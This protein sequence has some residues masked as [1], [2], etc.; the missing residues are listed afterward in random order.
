MNKKE[1]RKSFIYIRNSIT[2]EERKVFNK[3]IFSNF[4]NSTFIRNY[5]VFLIYVSVKSEVDTLDIIDCLLKTDKKVAVPHC[6]GKN[7]FF[8][9]IESVNDLV[10]GAFGI[11]SV[12]ISKSKRVENFD[13]T[14]CVVPGVSF[15]N[16]FNRLG[17]GGGYYDRF[18]SDNNITALGLC[19]ERCISD[20]LPAE[21]HD[22]KMDFVLTESCLRINKNKEGSKY[23]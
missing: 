10:N 4:I 13:K 12:D 19:Y 2:E 9:F 5:D 8:Y 23:G 6:D 14:L 15:D 17:Y 3:N 20:I 21:D 18:L 1:I 7:M 22:I 16:N 11:L